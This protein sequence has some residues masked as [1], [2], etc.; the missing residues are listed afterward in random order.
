[1]SPTSSPQLT[2][3]AAAQAELAARVLAK[4]RLIPFTQRI[5]P[6]YDAG[7]V[8]R[9]IARRLE[10][11][12]EDVAKGLSPRLMILMPPRHG[13][14]VAD[15]TPVLTTAGWKSHGDLLPGDKV[16]HPS[17]R[18]VE[19]LAVAQPLP[20]DCEV[21]F[22]DGAKILVH[23]NHEWA[24]FDRSR[25]VSRVVETKYLERR[26]LWT[27]PSGSRGG[28]AVFQLPER[29]ALDLPPRSLPIDP[30]VLGAWLGDGKSSSGQLCWAASDS[31]VAEEVNAKYPFTSRWTHQSTGVEYGAFPITKDLRAL[32]LLDNKHI[33]DTYILGS[34]AQRLQLLAGLIDTDGHV[35]QPTQRVRIATVSSKLAATI[36]VLVR[37]LGWRASRYTQ[38]PATS[39]SGIVGRQ[40][41]HYVSFTPTSPIPTR[42][43]RKQI[44]RTLEPQRAVGVV[45]VRRVPETTG[46]C[47]QVDSPDG[48]YLVGEHL[49]PTHNSELASRMFPAWHL[50]HHPDHEI[51]ACSYNVSLAMSFSRKVKEVLHD[52]AYQSVFTTRLHPDFQANEEWGIAGSRGGYV[53]AGVGGGITGKGAHILLIDDPIKNAEEA[54]SP[55]VREKLW[56]WYGSTAYTRLAPGA[57]VLVIQTWWHDDDLAGKLQTAMFSDPESDQ[58]E[59]VKYPAIA[60]HDEYLDTQ[61][62]LITYV[63]HNVDPT[64]Y[65]PYE[66]LQAHARAAA[67]KVDL[68]GLRFLRGKGGAL[69]PQRYD[70]KK[71]HAIRKTIPPRFWAALYQQNPVPDDGA[72][73]TKDH[74]RRA[75]LPP[76]RKANVYVAFDFAISEKKQNDYTVGV[77]GLQDENDV[78]HV[79]EVMRFKSG[80]GMFVV[81]SILNLC[82]KWYSPNL[83]LGF[84]DGQ[85]F[86]AIESLLKKRMRERKFYPSTQLLK[87]ITDKM[88][89]ARPLQGR[90]Q[91]GMVSFADGAQWFDAARAEML[92]FPAGVHDDQVDALAW[93][94]TMVVGREPPRQQQAKA[95][96]SWKDKLNSMGKATSFMGA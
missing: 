62:D 89:R 22:T 56:D 51:I 21:E 92:R 59:L 28:R 82:Q 48:L 29:S 67:Q 87:P 38:P 79:A 52:P 86:R 1:M 15:T 8:H 68:T 31:E 14:Q 19:V 12:S 70:T 73:F 42:I 46:R 10:R 44:S 35:E 81:E 30:Y 39:T 54:D 95:P 57:G 33:P 7:G 71:L 43:P 84:E 13:K 93:M 47:I 27:G 6:R 61:S 60:E 55:D 40:P 64:T 91:Q 36:E 58:F 37:S 25:G 11:F 66:P 90:M 63:S 9:D 69:H 77:V 53:A 34:V 49:T 78:L 16:F 85:I 2:Q 72:Y 88:A 20:Q 83:I 5:N 23:E 74:F 32:G 65:D 24:V 45:A 96:K 18:P 17:G 80:D 75:P 41:V 3:I 50:G 94:A 26:K 4:R 76:L